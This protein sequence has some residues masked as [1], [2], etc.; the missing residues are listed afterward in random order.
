M[1]EQ[2]TF[3]E[4]LVAFLMGLSA[5]CFFFWAVV[6]GTFKNVEEVK[7]KVMEVEDHER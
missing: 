7:Y 2:I 4:F 3:F 5:F 6:E 1:L